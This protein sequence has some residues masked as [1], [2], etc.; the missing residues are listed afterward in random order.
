MGWGPAGSTFAWRAMAGVSMG[1]GLYLV[2]RHFLRRPW[3]AA[4]VSLVLMSDAG[5]MW[6][7][8]VFMQ[9]MVA[10]GLLS[11]PQPGWMF[12]SHPVLLL[13][14]RLMNPG[15]SFGA[16][17]LHIFFMDRARLNP[18]R[19]RI[20]LAGANLGLLFYVFFYFWTA[21][22]VALGLIWILDRTRRAVW[23]KV[24]CIGVAVGLPALLFN[25]WI[26]SHTN[27]DW[28]QRTELFIPVSRLEGLS[29]TPVAILLA[30]GGLLWV[31]CRHRSLL[32]LWAFSTAGLLLLNQHLL[33]GF[34][35]CNDHWGYVRGL[36]FSL[37]FVLLAFLALMKLPWTTSRWFRVLTVVAV[38][39]HAGLGFWFRVEET[40]HSRE[41][42]TI[43]SD[44][45]S[46]RSQRKAVLMKGGVIAGAA[47]YVEFG[48]LMDGL[49]PLER[50]AQLSTGVD[51][52][53]WDGRSAL[54]AWLQGQDRATFES[55]QRE[56]FE[57][58][59]GPWAHHPEMRAE[60]VVNRLGIYDEVATAPLRWMDR[61]RVR[62]VALPV[63]QP[64]PLYLQDG[65]KRIESKGRWQVWERVGSDAG[66]QRRL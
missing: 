42:A 51:N 38:I 36:G 62:Y 12:G 2:T 1:A 55:R 8:P 30:V 49:R 21:S 52:R 7:R 17:L 56:F 44:F 57:T 15:V 23:F 47:R 59:M 37:L 58:C 6:A 41:S 25:A 5:F 46:F 63:E 18:D 24:G 16:L 54:D 9:W 11:D 35:L 61:F 4:A 22:V 26:T 39:I 3:L 33:T 32:H 19:R 48:Q 20:L 10:K 43:I 45:H 29:M 14:W 28:P 34:T 64:A 53:E 13:H 60:R 65:W 66:A 27:H 50:S 40:R 31:W